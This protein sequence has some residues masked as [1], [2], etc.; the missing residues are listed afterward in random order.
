MIDLSVPKKPWMS[1]TDADCID[2]VIDF[3]SPEE[4][5]LEWGSGGSTLYFGDGRNWIS[6]E[7]RREWADKI[8]AIGGNVVFCADP[9][10]YIFPFRDT[11]ILKGKFNVMLVDG[12]FREA[13]LNSAARRVA[14]DGI[15]FLHDARRPE[16]RDAYLNFKWFMRIGDDLMVFAK[17]EPVKKM[18]KVL[19][20]FDLRGPNTGSNPW[21]E[22]HFKE[23]DPTYLPAFEYA[24]PTKK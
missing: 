22:T 12:V 15:V 20:K 18:M 3:F 11:D 5:C 23:F 13:C 21:D 7:H 24:F 4:R 19:R 17:K 14:D 9:V 6:I 1:E 8:W 2:A 10:S 16:Y